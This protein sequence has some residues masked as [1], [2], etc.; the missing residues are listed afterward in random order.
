MCEISEFLNTKIRKKD[1]DTTS[2]T[3]IVHEGGLPYGS[4]NLSNDDTIILYKMINNSI[5]KG[6]KISLLERFNNVCPL[7]LDLDFKYKDEHTDRQYTEEFIKE[8]YEFICDKIKLIFSLSDINQLQMWVM[9]KDNIMKAPQN[10]YGSKDGLHLLFPDIISDISNYTKLIDAVIEDKD[11]YIEIMENTCNI[12]PSN[13]VD[14]I[15]DKSLY[16]PGNWFIYGCGKIAENYTY[17]LTN[18]YKL[19]EENVIKELPIDIYIQ[20]PLEIMKKNSVQLNTTTNVEYIGPEILKKK[21]TNNNVNMTDNN[22]Y[23]Y[24]SVV[25]INKLKGED[26]THISNIVNI[27]NDD[28]ASD[29]SS[30]MNFGYCIYNIAPYEF[31]N[32]IWHEF[33]KKCPEKYNE[34]ACNKQWDYMKRTAQRK[35]MTMGTLIYWAR[36]DDNESYERIL[37][38]SL[39]TQIIKSIKKEKA[40]GTHS[41]VTNVIHKYYKEEFVCAGLREN[42]WYYFDNTNGKWRLTEQGHMLRRRLSDDMIEVY[43]Y[44]S[45]KYKNMRGDD[46]ESDDYDKYDSFIKCCYIVILKLKDSNYKDKIM[47]E[48]KEKF[49]DEK[50][51]DKLNSNLQLLGLDNCVVDLRY[52]VSEDVYDIQFREGMPSDYISLSVDYDLPIDRKLLPL[53]LDEVKEIIPNVLDN[54]DDLNRDLEDFIKKILPFEDVNEYTFRFLSSC[55]SGEVREEK[56]YFWTGSGS[57]GKSK[58]IELIEATLGDYSKIMDVAYITTKRGSSSAASPELERIRYARFVYMSEPDKD[59]QIFVGK[60]KQITGGDKMSSRGLFKEASD[61]KPQFKIILMCNDLPKLANIDGGV[62]RRIEVVDFPSKFIDNPRPTQNN[63]HQ[64]KMDMQLGSKLKQ[65]NLLFLLK[66]LSYY[67]IYDEEGT[68]APSSVSQA[69]NV[70]VIENDI[71]QKW[72]CEDL[73]ECDEVLSFNNIYDSFILWCENEGINHKKYAKSDI[74]KELEKMQLITKYGCVYG[75]KTKDVA[76]NGTKSYP[77]FNYCPIEDLED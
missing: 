43:E 62:T 20:N 55:L 23:E 1:D 66:L 30:W 28:R 42:S 34:D 14:Q 21:P 39:E 13:N 36:K 49:Y 31:G 33:S 70:Y 4:Y 69:T 61:F 46:P 18:I 60:L 37:K 51:M 57:N 10:G 64:Y 16:N 19:T 40:C 17:K 6:N 15:F 75:E 8:T 24:V 22:N 71:I 12:M 45:K 76:P 53:T 67:K 59:D 56:F 7:I 54:F 9:E 63:P 35:V 27:L 68:K 25:N 72:F 5:K 38:D 41:D 26:R 32:K 11:H 2:I 74:K 77:K 65:W 48:C 3:H 58:V 47:K 29:Q 44:F 52:E 50:F 73:V